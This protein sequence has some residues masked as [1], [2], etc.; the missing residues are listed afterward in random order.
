MDLRV[1]L[2]GRNGGR[3]PVAI[4][5]LLSTGLLKLLPFGPSLLSRLPVVGGFLSELDTLLG[6]PDEPAPGAEPDETLVAQLALSDPQ[7]RQTLL[8]EIER[9]LSDDVPES[10]ELKAR[11]ER[12]RELLLRLDATEIAAKDEPPP[13]ADATVPAEVAAEAVAPPPPPFASPELLG[14]KEE[15]SRG[16][17]AL[18]GP[19][20]APAAPAAPLADAGGLANPELVERVLRATR[21]AQARSVSRLRLTLEPPE[22]GELSLELTLRDRVLHGAFFTDAPGA[23][24]ALAAR[25]GELKDALER[26]GLRVGELSVNPG[27][28]VPSGAAAFVYPDPAPPRA[29]GNLDLKA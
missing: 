13:A 9:R 21:Q 4:P 28:A 29:A 24:E 16:V 12:L 5:P 18:G 25:L 20:A 3:A 11:L 17:A 27:G 14:R 8:R 10:P 26:R 1:R 6:G 7:V 19:S 23:A 22:L 15:P 2:E